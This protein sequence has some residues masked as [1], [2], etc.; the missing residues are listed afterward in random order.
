MLK[1]GKAI[2]IV[3]IVLIV[4]FAVA[5]I[6]IAKTYYDYDKADNTYEEIQSEY[7][8]VNQEAL[9]SAPVTDGETQPETTPE[10]PISIHFDGL[11]ARNEDVIGWLY[12]PDT[13]INYPVA[14]GKDNDEYLHRDLD[15]KYLVSGTLF[16]DYRNGKLNEDPYHIIYGHNMKNGT[17]FNGLVKY[18]DQAYYDQHPVMYY[19]TPEGNYKIELFAG[20]IVKRDDRIYIPDQDQGEL[21]ALLNEYRERSMFKA[22]VELTETDTIVT[23]STCS[24]EFNSARYVVIGKLVPV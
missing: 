5:A 8:A 21:F 14:Q 20:L 1:Q 7:V 9:P 22:D 12:C 19:L 24:Y 3:K 18:K 15:G 16:A 2:K 13:P 23:L 6:N 17:M 4:V 10:I 11:L